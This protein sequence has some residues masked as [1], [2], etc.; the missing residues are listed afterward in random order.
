MAFSLLVLKHSR[1]L[2]SEGV[3]L[4]SACEHQSTP[5]LDGQPTAPLGHT[6]IQH[7][8]L[9]NAAGNCNTMVNVDLLAPASPQTRNICYNSTLSWG[10]R[11]FSVH[12]NL[13]IPPTDDRNI[14]MH[15]TVFS[16]L[17]SKVCNALGHW[18]PRIFFGYNPFL[19]R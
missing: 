6:P 1:A 17:F 8:P 18:F 19:Q 15:L 14:I 7:V 10:D 16:K 12:Y 13:R 2:L 9:L 11:N 4:S 3:S 5:N